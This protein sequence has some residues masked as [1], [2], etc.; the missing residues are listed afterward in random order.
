ML[1]DRLCRA[2]ERHECLDFLRHWLNVARLF[3]FDDDGTVPAP[4][5]ADQFALPFAV[6]A[7]NSG[8]RAC[9]IFHQQADDWTTGHQFLFA[10]DLLRLMQHFSQIG[11]PVVPP[12]VAQS[13]SFNPPLMLVAH[14]TC[15]L[16]A[17][18]NGYRLVVGF[19]K[20]RQWYIKGDGIWVFPCENHS[21]DTQ[22][23]IVASIQH[24]AVMVSAINDPQRFV[25]E[26]S[27]VRERHWDKHRIL[28]SHDRPQYTILKPQEIRQRLG[29]PPPEEPGTS[30][31]PH[32]R[33]GHFRT[34]HSERFVYVKGQ[35]KWIDAMWIGPSES[36]VRNTRYRVVLDRIGV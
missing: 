3:A 11:Q 31:C 24:S 18:C 30:K 36:I 15:R 16:E 29:L 32:E 5:Q 23:S 2:A 35:R 28:R 21:L 25:L 26:Q 27:P 12:S 8:E 6:T 7:V 20:N 9:T 13:L 17:D 19:Y 14:G 1:F 33:R 22:Q 10:Y 4:K 34:F